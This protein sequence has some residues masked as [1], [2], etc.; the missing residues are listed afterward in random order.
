[1]RILVTGFEPFASSPINPSEQV[2]HRLVEHPP[3][4]VAFTGVV[5]AVDASHAPV[6]LLTQLEAMQPDVVVCFGEANGR[7]CISLEQIAINLLD[8]R[9]PDNCGK[10][11]SNQPV[12]P[13]APDGY[14]TSLPLAAIQVTLQEHDIPVERSL[15]AGTYLCNQIFF[16]VMHWR[17]SHGLTFPAGFIHLPSLPEQVAMRTDKGPSMC[18]DLLEQA[19]RL[20]LAECIRNVGGQ[21]ARHP[22]EKKQ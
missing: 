16:T 17:A 21:P 11:I 1:M 18:L 2:V 4:G 3:A 15:S 22:K 5:L 9:I 6:Q 20:I 14:F 12:I 8:F 10:Q 19:S 7:S 13:K